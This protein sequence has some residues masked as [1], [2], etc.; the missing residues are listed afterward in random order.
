MKLKNYLLLKRTL[1]IQIFL[2]KPT[3][4]FI[5]GESQI[6]IYY[7]NND[8]HAEKIRFFY[9]TVSQNDLLSSLA[10]FLDTGPYELI[11]CFGI[12]Y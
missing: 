7:S 12:I 1:L 6:I 9:P 2:G 4:T 10:I 3:G 11:R 5:K 8:N